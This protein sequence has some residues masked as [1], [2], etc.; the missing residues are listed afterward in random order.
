MTHYSSNSANETLGPVVVVMWGGVT[1]A[2]TTNSIL[3]L[4]L[5][6]DTNLYDPV[7]I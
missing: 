3:G 6:C 4:R 7:M 1:T 2:I 5:Y